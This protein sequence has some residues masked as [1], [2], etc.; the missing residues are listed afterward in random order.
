[1]LLA[2]GIAVL[3]L[4]GQGGLDLEETAFFLMAG[5]EFL[6]PSCNPLPGRTFA[7]EC[8]VGHGRDEL[9]PPLRRPAG[10]HGRTGRHLMTRWLEWSDDDEGIRRTREALERRPIEEPVVEPQPDEPAQLTARNVASRRDTC[11]TASAPATPRPPP[12]LRRLLAR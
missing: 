1:M 5:S 11:S 9:R 8:G 6:R 4:G 2:E 12:L 3:R 7:D 10:R